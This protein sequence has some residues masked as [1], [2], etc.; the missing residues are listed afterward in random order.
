M[1]QE[2]ASL[3][4]HRF[5]HQSST[6]ALMQCCHQLSPAFAATVIGW[7]LHCCP[8]PTFPSSSSL[9]SSLLAAPS[10]IPFGNLLRR[11]Q[12]AVHLPIKTT[13]TT[14]TTMRF[15]WHQRL[16]PPKLGVTPSLR[17]FAL[18]LLHLVINVIV[19]VS[20]PPTNAVASALLQLSSS[21]T[22]R[23]PCRAIQEGVR[24]AR[25]LPPPL[26]VIIVVL[27]SPSSSPPPPPPPPISSL[28][29]PY[30]TLAKYATRPP[31][32][33]PKRHANNPSY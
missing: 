7:L 29:P 28:H 1:T 4:P 9:L 3:P 13:T 24:L 6:I 32:W 17:L 19:I 21:P 18:L 10:S 12:T 23:P 31:P 30:R 5:H 8:P 15:P 16:M 33:G 22:E 2:V 11:R 26:I 27:V 14:T 20:A 25:L